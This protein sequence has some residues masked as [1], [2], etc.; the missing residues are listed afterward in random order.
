MESEGG[1][2]QGRASG[3]HHKELHQCQK[4]AMRKIWS[5]IQYLFTSGFD[6]TTSAL[7]V[8]LKSGSVNTAPRFLWP[9]NVTIEL[10]IRGLHSIGRSSPVGVCIRSRQSCPVRFIA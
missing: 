5:M 10:W 3:H 4:P 1:T 8:G 6:I 2:W 7:L 9:S